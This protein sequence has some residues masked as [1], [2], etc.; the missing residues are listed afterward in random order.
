MYSFYLIVLIV[1][2]PILYINTEKAEEEKKREQ[3]KIKKT[4]KQQTSKNRN[5]VCLES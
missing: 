5:E 2:Y 1:F 4:P 3:N